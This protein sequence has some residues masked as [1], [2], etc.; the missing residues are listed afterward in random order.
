MNIM[1]ALKM[2]YFMELCLIALLSIP[3]CSIGDFIGDPDPC[4]G[5]IRG[6]IIINNGAESTFSR[7]VEVQIDVRGATQM[8]VG[9][10]GCQNGYYEYI[11]ETKIYTLSE[12]FG[13]KRVKVYF[14][15]SNNCSLYMYDSITLLD[16]N[17]RK[18]LVNKDSVISTSESVTLSIE[19]RK[20]QKDPDSMR[21]SNDNSNWSE[22]E[23]YSPAKDWNLSEN[24]G[25]K[26]VYAEFSFSGGELIQLN[27]DIV[28][29]SM[30]KLRRSDPQS[31]SSYGDSASISSDGSVVVIGAPYGDSRIK[32]S[33]CAYVFR[34]SGDTWNETKLAA[35]DADDDDRFGGSVAISSN[36]NVII[37]GAN[38]DRDIGVQAGSAYIY[39]W[40]G[41]SW[42]ET[43]I[44]PS[45]S[46]KYIHFGSSVA[47]SSDGDVAVVS[48]PCYNNSDSPTGSVYIFKDN[49]NSW[50]ETKL[51]ASDDNEYNGF[52][53][54]LSISSDG[55]TIVVG[56]HR[57]DENDKI[58]SGSMYIYK[59]SGS[60]WEETKIFTDDS[61]DYYHFGASV[62]ISSDGNSIIVGAPGTYRSYIKTNISGFAYVYKWDGS[63]WNSTKLSPSNGAVDDHF[64]ASVAISS[65]GEKAVVSSPR[66]NSKHSLVY[67]Y[68]WDGATWGESKFGPI[69]RSLSM[70]PDG[71]NLI[72]GFYLYELF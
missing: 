36:G 19:V 59:W 18:F 34:K 23:S 30:T 51:K 49:G 42:Q 1:K 55:N 66:S 70:T 12:G 69:G 43:K 67:V 63:S 54:S 26:K 10:K 5:E 21:F 9:Y 62:S 28:F 40:D 46:A 50:E 3:G 25:E 60:S 13:T 24:Y 52:G 47:I 2:S 53:D 22:W 4:D 41:S 31:Y 57:D 65:D 72:T 61:I 39:K 14:S 48:A 37:V 7:D 58:E 29:M 11:A 33:G 6:S 16:A 56:A 68:E 15:N 17:A 35:S 44:V 45:D 64:G 8:C 71:N 27:D 20:D 38:S 32:D